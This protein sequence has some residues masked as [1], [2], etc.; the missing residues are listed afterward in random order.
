MDFLNVKEMRPGKLKK[1]LGKENIMDHLELHRADCLASHDD[2]EHY[3]FVLD[4]LGTMKE[5]DL[6]PPPLITG[7]DL[8]E[9][10]FE[11]GPL[12]KRILSAVEEAQLNGEIE[13][14]EQALEMAVRIASE[15]RQ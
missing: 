12:F 10:G 11:P 14:A 2:L 15:D 1:F 13:T 8:I 6:K 4:L 7:R 9:L 5:E 3:E